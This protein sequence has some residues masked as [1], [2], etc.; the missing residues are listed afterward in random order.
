MYTTGTKTITKNKQRK[1]HK[2]I[3]ILLSVGL[4]ELL[5]LTSPFWLLTNVKI[6]G[7]VY[8]L[9]EDL[10]KWMMVIFPVL[11][12]IGALSTLRRRTF[13][14]V[15]INAAMGM[16]VLLLIRSFERYMIV[17][18][19]ILFFEGFV[20]VHAATAW[21]IGTDP[22]LWRKYANRF[23]IFSRR[24]FVYTTLILMTGL[25]VLTYQKDYSEERQPEK[26]D[27]VPQETAVS[28]LKELIVEESEWDRL[29]VAEREK[30]VTKAT[31][32]ALE[33]CGV[34]EHDLTIKYLFAQSNSTLGAFN[35]DCSIEYNEAWLSA[36]S[37][38]E[39]YDVILHECF[40]YYQSE[41]VEIYR[42]LR[43]EGYPVDEMEDFS[44]LRLFAEA[45]D[46]YESDYFS[47]DSYFDNALERTAREYAEKRVS[48]LF[49]NSRQE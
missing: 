7:N 2:F 23:L 25:H 9:R 10:Q 18:A 13:E 46:S 44:R 12:L 1:L 33:E 42:K 39:V 21:L 17:S 22:S 45:T 19:I 48:E 20:L 36:A 41:G 29:S 37:Q 32:A 6:F 30:I 16:C 34:R 47:Y 38:E 15:F 27:I 4:A 43:E 31:A 26:T 14:N 28:P 40:H 5:I 11:A 8:I 49:G 35:E 24:V 3:Y